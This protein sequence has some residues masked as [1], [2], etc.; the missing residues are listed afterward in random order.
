MLYAL[1]TDAMVFTPWTACGR[2][3]EF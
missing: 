1:A 2:V 3:A